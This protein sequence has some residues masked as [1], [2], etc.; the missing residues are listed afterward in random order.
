MWNRSVCACECIKACKINEYSDIKNRSCKK[1]LIG[2]L[3]L[4]CEGKI[5]NRTRISLV[6]K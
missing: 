1:R 6:D 5:L 2:K 4:A 3:V